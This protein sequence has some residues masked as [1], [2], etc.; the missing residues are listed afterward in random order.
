MEAPFPED[1]E[2]TPQASQPLN[3][4]ETDVNKPQKTKRSPWLFSGVILGF[5]LGSIATLGILPYL[6]LSIVNQLHLPTLTVLEPDVAHIAPPPSITYSM[7]QEA[8]REEQKPS[9]VVPTMDIQTIQNLQASME[10]LQQHLNS[11]PP[12]K[13]GMASLSQD[14]QTMHANQ[15]SIRAAQVSVESM[16][17]H[18]RLSWVLHPSS[19]LPQIRLAW[20]EIVLLPSLS[21]EK[22]QQSNDMLALAQQRSEDV[23]HWQQELDRILASYH[24]APKS[25]HNVIAD[26]LPHEGTFAPLSTWISQQFH[27]QEAQHQEV[28]IEQLRQQIIAIKQNLSLEKWP[29]SNMWKSLRSRLQLHMLHDDAQHQA[30]TLPEDFSSIQSDIERL[31]QTA[32]DWLQ[33]SSK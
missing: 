8:Q 9:G 26:W 33:E 30:I 15:A 31:H 23:Y 19:H 28:A 32:R 27:L 3:A 12:L 24:S 11:F 13:E 6:P 5:M 10:Q 4:N 16:Q 17:L 22:H 20:E 21:P 7:Q 25:S 2:A 29:D 14:L 18:S 1:K